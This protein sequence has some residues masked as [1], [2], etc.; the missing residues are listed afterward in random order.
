M[1]YGSQRVCLF[2]K[3]SGGSGRVLGSVV[4]EE[5]ALPYEVIVVDDG[6]DDATA[7]VCERY[8]LE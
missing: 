4:I 3:D 7:F 8:G 6:S 5:L 2:M 1:E